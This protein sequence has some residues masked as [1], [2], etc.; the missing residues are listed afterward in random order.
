[1]TRGLI[2]TCYASLR[3]GVT[4]AQVAEAY[5]QE[6][7]EEPFV[8]VTPSFPA[9][10][11]TLGSNWCL[12]HATVDEPNARLVA[13]GVLDNLVK[14]AAGSAVQNMN[15]MLGLPEEMGLAALPLWP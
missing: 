4:S 9:T 13:V 6:Y 12:L 5:A 10:K 14:G 15:A 1:M 8:R 2:T 7:A 11:A 3:E